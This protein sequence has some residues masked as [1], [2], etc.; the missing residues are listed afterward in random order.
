ML[1]RRCRSMLPLSFSPC[2]PFTLSPCHLS[3]G[4]T[5]AVFA[6]VLPAMIVMVL[7]AAAPAF[8]SDT[9]E[10]T[11]HDLSVQSPGYVRAVAEDQICVFCHAPHSG[12]LAPAGWNRHTTSNY[13]RVYQSS[14]TN[15]PND[16]PHTPSRMCLSCHDGTMPIGQVL[17][18][19]P[20]TRSP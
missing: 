19:R 5:P 18:P 13:Y 7:L 16:Q 1:L 9:I 15:A 6:G 11:P 8:A 4:A 14:T 12:A 20:P 10:N 17:S 2:H 3:Q